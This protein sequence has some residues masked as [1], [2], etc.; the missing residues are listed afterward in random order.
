MIASP[1]SGY[2]SLGSFL[3]TVVVILERHLGTALYQ[4]QNF[5]KTPGHRSGAQLYRDRKIACSYQ[6]VKRRPAKPRD[7]EDFSA[8]DEAVLPDF[9]HVTVPPPAGWILQ[10]QKMLALNDLLAIAEKNYCRLRLAFG[11]H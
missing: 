9:A 1:W 8:P 11:E 2:M 6:S 10:G 5:G 3:R 7:E 4:K